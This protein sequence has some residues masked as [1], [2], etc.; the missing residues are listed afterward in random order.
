M[1]LENT[2]WSEEQKNII[3][4]SEFTKISISD[5]IYLWLALEYIH[6]KTV[7]IT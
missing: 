7:H 3:K 1:I 5:A 4:A 2:C 6:Y